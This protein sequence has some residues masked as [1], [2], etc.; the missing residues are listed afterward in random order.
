M[1]GLGREEDGMR[2]ARWDGW[3]ATLFGS[4]RLLL[5]LLLLLLRLLRISCEIWQGGGMGRQ[6]DAAASYLG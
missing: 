2:R 5:L 1:D 4:L 3:R 6:E